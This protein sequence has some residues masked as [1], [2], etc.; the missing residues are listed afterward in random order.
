M[1]VGGERETREREAESGKGNL[2]LG[3]FYKLVFV[4]V[5]NVIELEE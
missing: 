2:S 1:R 4:S 3:L 5:W